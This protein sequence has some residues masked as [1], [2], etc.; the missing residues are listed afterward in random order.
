M[1]LLSYVLYAIGA[2]TQCAI[3]QNVNGVIIR[4]VNYSSIVLNWESGQNVYYWCYDPI[5][6]DADT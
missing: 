6:C 3:K 1:L 5:I 2:Y 4:Y